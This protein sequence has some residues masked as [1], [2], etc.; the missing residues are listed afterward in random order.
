MVK[1]T[2]AKRRKIPTSKFA[3]PDRSYPIPDR[4]HAVLAKAMASR[5]ASPGEKARID[6]KAN[7]KLGEK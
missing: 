3:G 4:A 5:Y 6:A 1:L 2:A 7:A